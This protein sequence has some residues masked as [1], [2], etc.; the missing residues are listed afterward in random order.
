MAERRLILDA[1]VLINLLATAQLRQV[2]AACQ[3]RFVLVQEVATETFFLR[4]DAAPEG[5]T[6]VDLDLLIAAGDLEVVALDPNEFDAYVGYAARVDDG[7]A[8]SIAVADARNWPL[9]TDDRAALRLLD[10]IHVV[11]QRYT[12]PSLLRIWAATGKTECGLHA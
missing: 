5:R 6:K 8:A 3:A 1:C 9:A 10:D 4:D 7:E 12:T 11:Q 2:A